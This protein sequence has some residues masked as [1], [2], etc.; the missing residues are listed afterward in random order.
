MRLATRII[1]SA[2]IFSA[3]V[4]SASAQPTPI[5]LGATTTSGEDQVWLMKARPELT[6]NQ[7]KMYTLDTFPFRGGDLRIKAYLA[8]Q[9]DGVVTTGSGAVT[10]ATK[11]VPLTVTAALSEEDNNFYSTS[12]IVLDKSGLTSANDLKGKTIGVNAVHDAIEFFARLALLKAKL[13]PDRDVKWAAIPPPALGDALRTGRIDVAG[14]SQPFFSNEKARGGVR[15]L[16]TAEDAAGFKDEFVLAF[17]P[18]FL[19][20]HQDAM[21]AFSADLV[22]AT[23]YYMDHTVDARKAILAAK[24]VDMDPSVYLNMVAIPRKRDA[25]PSLAYFKALQSALKLTGYISD[26][27]D[28]E[29]LIDASLLPAN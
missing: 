15:T 21:K 1:G 14:M 18:D 17:N 8:G 25:A 26:Q 28:V 5:R 3:L 23:A 20:Q 19:K 11:G 24:L 4:A 22:A 16:F 29:K 12:Y 13:D 6:P 27:I 10:A 7:G 2:V 9:V